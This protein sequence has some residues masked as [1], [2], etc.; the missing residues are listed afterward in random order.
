V[1]TKTCTK[2]GEDKPLSEYYKHPNGGGG[3]DPKCKACARAYV[4]GYYRK[5]KA[6]RQAEPAPVGRMSNETPG[7]FRARVAVASALQEG[8]ITKPEACQKCERTGV[9]LHAH[10][11]DYRRLMEIWWLC[12]VCFHNRRRELKLSTKRA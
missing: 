3:L 4:A 10:H 1:L 12:G 5:R 9:P 6:Q 2:C 11:E 7:E 8:R